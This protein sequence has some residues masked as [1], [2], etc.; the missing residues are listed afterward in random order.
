MHLIIND[1]EYEFKKVEVKYK[2]K[3]LI[4]N[5]TAINGSLIQS[6]VSRENLPFLQEEFELKIYE[7]TQEESELLQG[8][9]GLDNIILQ[10]REPEINKEYVCNMLT[11]TFFLTGCIFRDYAVVALKPSQPAESYIKKSRWLVGGVSTKQLL[12]PLN[13]SSQW[14]TGSISTKEN[15]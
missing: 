5:K 10:F 15:I 8:S 6:V 3:L 7:L 9:C 11:K 2:P 1:Q 14:L 12:Q 4:K 13:P